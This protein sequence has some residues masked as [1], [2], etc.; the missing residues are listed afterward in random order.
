MC[1]CDQNTRISRQK[2]QLPQSGRV[3]HSLR[4]KIERARWE[5][6]VSR[7]SLVCRNHESRG[8]LST[9]SVCTGWH[10]VKT[11]GRQRKEALEK[12]KHKPK[13]LFPDVAPLSGEVQQL[14]FGG[15]PVW[16]RGLTAPPR[17]ALRN[18]HQHL[19][20]TSPAH[21]PHPHPPST[22]HSFLLLLIANTC[23]V[24][25]GSIAKPT[26]RALSSALRHVPGP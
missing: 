20:A 21:P 11:S 9:N 4:P 6:E 1:F 24:F 23:G 19:A 10:W 13:S 2:V 17:G 8:S 25:P 7:C 16:E 22:F 14:W 3:I 18:S 12:T 26:V 5:C 15:R